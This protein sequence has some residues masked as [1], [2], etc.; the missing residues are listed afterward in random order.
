MASSARR[1]RSL[2]A[3]TNNT[4]QTARGR[5]GGG[6]RVS[7]QGGAHKPLLF[8]QKTCDQQACRQILQFMRVRWV[9]PCKR[10]AAVA[11][12]APE[13]PAPAARPLLLLLLLAVCGSCPPAGVQGSKGGRSMHCSTS[14]AHA[15][16]TGLRRLNVMHAA[17]TARAHVV[18][19]WQ[20]AARQQWP[21]HLR[22]RSRPERYTLYVRVPMTARTHAWGCQWSTK[23]DGGWVRTSG[24][25][26][27]RNAASH[28]EPLVV[29]GPLS[30]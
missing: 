20:G 1:L 7:V 18:A 26:S 10:A 6:S 2:S 3:C 17:S 12:A 9:A 30:F 25:A 13:A 27:R 15:D 23:H 28:L 24:A 5:C 29:Q 21:R 14:G 22:A 16:G 19:R 11:A 8:N 4:Q